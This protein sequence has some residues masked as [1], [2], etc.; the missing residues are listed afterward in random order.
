MFFIYPASPASNAPSLCD[1]ELPARSAAIP[2]T[3][4]IQSLL[5]TS[6]PYQLKTLDSGSSPEWRPL[7]PAISLP[8]RH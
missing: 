5:F 2:A 8:F 7:P 1:G 4:G 3:A 6:S